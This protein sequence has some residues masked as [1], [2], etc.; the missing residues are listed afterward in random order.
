MTDVPQ[1]IV[2]QWCVS[3]KLLSITGFRGWQVACDNI[4]LHPYNDR[5]KA[6]PGHCE[7]G[8]HSRP[9]SCGKWTVNAVSRVT[10][11]VLVTLHLVHSVNDLHQL[12]FISSNK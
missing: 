12:F 4:G 2:L 8:T 9:T 10:G 7:A 3:L 11:C 5:R 1:F 6:V